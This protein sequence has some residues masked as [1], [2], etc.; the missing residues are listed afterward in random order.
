[1]ILTDGAENS[2]TE[3][4]VRKIKE[5]IEHK[6]LQGWRFVF[7]GANQDAFIAASR[8]GIDTESTLSF[9]TDVVDSAIRS[10]GSAVS[11]MISQESDTI[12]FTDMER[13]A[14]QPL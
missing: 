11:R 4:T 2:S 8:I 6:R 5:L 7:L 10:A 14:S 13:F 1:V 9:D 3:Y 12:R